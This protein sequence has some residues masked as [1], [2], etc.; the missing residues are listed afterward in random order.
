V[1]YIG[2]DSPETKH[3]SVDLECYGQEASIK[4]NELVSGKEIRL[5][6]DVSEIDKY[7]RLLRYVYVG[8][9]FVNDYLVRQGYA[10]ASSY[11]PDIKH[12]E[13][14]RKAEKEARENKRGLWSGICDKT[15]TPTPESQ[16]QPVSKPVVNPTQPP[17]SQPQTSGFTCDCNKLCGQ[18]SSCNEA[19]F[20]LNQ[21]GCSK[22]DGDSDGVPCESICN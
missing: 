8:D 14:F 2:I 11:P 15:T 18:M 4:N 3:P 7:G 6:K 22:R 16:S 13:Q 10:Q 17:T 9:I 12:Q 19:Y 1:R 20:Q 5:E 21:C